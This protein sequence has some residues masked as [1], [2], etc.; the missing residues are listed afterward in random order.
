MQWLT[1]YSSSHK[2]TPLCFL[3]TT[4]TTKCLQQPG[5]R[6]P[7][8]KAVK[9]NLAY[10][11]M[12]KCGFRNM[13]RKQVYL[14]SCSPSNHCKEARHARGWYD[15]TTNQQVITLDS[16]LMPLRGQ[17]TLAN[18]FYTSSILLQQTYTKLS[19]QLFRS[20]L[21]N[22]KLSC[23]ASVLC[24]E[25]NSRK[26]CRAAKPVSLKSCGRANVCFSIIRKYQIFK[27]IKLHCQSM[28][29][30]SNQIK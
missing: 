10:T 24:K 14:T 9:K 28:H 17:E 16:S 18:K 4:Q 21:T 11:A 19:I 27:M 22:V 12:E 1:D 20:R 30:K 13:L 3:L 8:Y 15:V 23:T 25:A 29:C 26:A 5:C 6:L 7:W 2:E